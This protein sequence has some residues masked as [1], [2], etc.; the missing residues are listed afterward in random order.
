MSKT[1]YE[2]LTGKEPDETWTE[3]ELAEKEKDAKKTVIA[4]IEALTGEKP[5][6]KTSAEN[7]IETL[8]VAKAPKEAPDVEL[9]ETDLMIEGNQ[10]HLL[11]EDHYFKDYKFENVIAVHPSKR[12]PRTMRAGDFYHVGVIPAINAPVVGRTP[13]YNA[14]KNKQMPYRVI[15]SMFEWQ[16]QK[17]RFEKATNVIYDVLHDPTK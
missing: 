13:L 5:H 11:P 10:T 17:P 16:D 2:V 6:H 9:G 14:E 1:D 8:E 12:N 4:Q 15:Y 3:K 7:L